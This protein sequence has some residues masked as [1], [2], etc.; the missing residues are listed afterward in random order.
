MPRLDR[1][2]REL[3]KHAVVFMALGDHM[4]LMLLTRLCSGSLL[5]ITRLTE[6]THI[7]RQAITKHLRVLEDAGLIRV[8]KRGRENHYEIEKESLHAAQQ[9]LASISRQWD[10]ALARLKTFVEQ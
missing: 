1:S 4:R 8:I 9:A 3:R 5:S 10:I 2:A 6:G 7:T